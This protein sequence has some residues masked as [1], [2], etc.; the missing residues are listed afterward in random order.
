MV[1]IDDAKKI[2]R[3]TGSTFVFLL[4]IMIPISIGVKLLSEFGLIDVIGTHLAPAMGV[5]GLP[6]EFGLVLATA[7]LVNIY[8]A[9]IVFFNCLLFIPILLLKSPSSPV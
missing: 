4:K 3:D 8:G 2:L 6:G 5:V 7:M 1:L 9:L